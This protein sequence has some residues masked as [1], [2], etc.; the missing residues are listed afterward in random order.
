MPDGVRT[1]ILAD[2]GFGDQE[3]YRKITELGMD[4]VIRFRECI[5]KPITGSLI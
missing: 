1:T 3:R 2:R 5:R 4:Y